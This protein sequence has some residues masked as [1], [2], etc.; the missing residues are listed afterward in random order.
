MSRKINFLFLRYLK[1]TMP[2]VYMT[3]GIVLLFFRDT[4]FA[5]SGMYRTAFGV[6]LLVYGALRFYQTFIKKSQ[7][8]E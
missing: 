8:E 1:F 2:V 4:L 6:M 7:D 5:I 3:L